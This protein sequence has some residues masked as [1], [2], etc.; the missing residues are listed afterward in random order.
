MKKILCR[1][2]NF[3]GQCGLG[4]DVIHTFDKF[5]EVPIPYAVKNV[6]TN[7]AHSFALGEDEKTVYYWGFNWDIRSFF[8]TAAFL[9]IFPRLINNFKVRI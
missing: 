5:I 1:G 2:L 8:R 9:Q 7:L 6:Y 3:H 4:N